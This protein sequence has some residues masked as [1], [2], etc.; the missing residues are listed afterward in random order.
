MTSA[1]IA[2]RLWGIAATLLGG[3]SLTFLI[4]HLIP[5]DPVSMILGDYFT[6]QSYN[7]L[8]HQLGLDRPLIVQYF[9][10]CKDV[11]NFNLGTS[12]QNRRPVAT[13]IA[14]QFPYTIELALLSVIIAVTTSIPLGIAAAWYRNRWIDYGSMAFASMMVAAPEFLLG[15]TLVLVFALYLGWLPSYG[16]GD[17]ND[18]MS[19]IR[20]LILPALALGLREIALLA[21]MTRSAV[22]EVLAQDYVRTARAKG[23]AARVIVVK[24]VLKNALVPVITVIGVDLAYLL[25]GVVVI[26][27]VFSR[28]GLGGLLLKSILNRD[29]PQ[30]QGTLLVLIT[31]AVLV[32]AIVDIAYTLI[33]PRVRYT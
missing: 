26:E 6:K 11:V 29:Y 5:G 3:V 4:I 13:N 20:H 23:L 28:P 16:V 12:L 15:I 33:D 7:D 31:I 17:G 25:G 8:K 32:N 1:R 2:G 10:Y 27:A 30:I 21:R 24:H 14:Q 9:A 18:G 19:I 22:L